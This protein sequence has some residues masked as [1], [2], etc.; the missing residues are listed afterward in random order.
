M[1]TYTYSVSAHHETREGEKW[2]IV[3]HTGKG[4]VSAG[5][6]ERIGDS[7]D[8]RTY[9]GAKCFRGT[10]AYDVR[11]HAVLDYEQEGTP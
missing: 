6:V 10:Q 2:T 5:S 1:A 11:A 7:Y 3:A 4:T 9:A 8:V